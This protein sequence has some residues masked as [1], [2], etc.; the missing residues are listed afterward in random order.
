MDVA[1][2]RCGVTFV[3]DRAGVTGDD[4]ASHN[5]MWDMSILQ[6][7]PGLR[8]ADQGIGVTVVDP[9]WVLPVPAEL[10]RMAGAH[11]LVV[12]VEDSGRHGGFGWSLA[13]ALRDAGVDVPFR[14]LGI[15]QRFLAHGSRDEVLADL[16]LTAQDVARAVTGW[17]AGLI[18]PADEPA[19]APAPGSA[20]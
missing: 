13:A 17:A 12:S 20:P 9:R 7:V 2:H 1:L 15:P 10:V 19:A 4:G 11:R 6:V 8:L 3:L 16:G 18:K 14:D 5:G